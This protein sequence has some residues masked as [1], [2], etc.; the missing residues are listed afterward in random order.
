M[1]P[2]GMPEPPKGV[3]RNSSPSQ[4]NGDSEKVDPGQLPELTW[5]HKLSHVR[6]DLPSFG[7]KWREAVKMAGL[8]FRLGQHIVEETSKGRTAIIDPMKKRTA[9]SGQGVPLGG[10]GAGSIGRS[11]KGEFQRWQL[12]P[13]ACEDKPVLANQFSAFISRQ[14]GRKYSTVLH[15][16][17]PDLPKNWI[18]GL[19]PE[20]TEIYLSCTLP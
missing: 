15:P 13:G 8:G 19:E 16:G 6:Y 5:E 9:K 4:T 10:I 3:S 18:L 12:F 2:N 1:K 11:Y 7:L 14:D 20:W 17:K